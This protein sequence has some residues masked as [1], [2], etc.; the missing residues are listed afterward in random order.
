MQRGEH[1]WDVDGTLMAMTSL[2]VPDFD[3]RKQ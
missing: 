2:A 3:E 1:A